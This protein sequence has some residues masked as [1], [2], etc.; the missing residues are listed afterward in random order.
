[1]G[2]T[3]LAM[4][5]LTLAATMVVAT[6]VSQEGALQTLRDDVRLGPPE[7]VSVPSA[8]AGT[9][10]EH[11]TSHEPNGFENADTDSL[12]L[13]GLY[14]AGAAVTSPIWVPTT[15]LGD[16]LT[17]A[18][19]F[20][21]YPYDD[22]SGYIQPLD[23]SIG[24]KP[25]AVRLDV[26]YVETFDCLDNLG[27]HLLV[28]SA[29]RL[30]VDASWNHLEERFQDNRY[31]SLEIGDV[32]LVYRFAQG[33][34]AEFR[35]GLGVNWLSDAH[36]TNLGFNFTYS[37]DFY[38]RKPWVLSAVIDWGTLGHTGLFRGRTTVGVVFHHVETYVGYEYS[39][40]GRTQW[41]GLI[42][43]LRFWF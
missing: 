10:M 3:L 15:F 39:D 29:S 42:G 33:N 32:N 17:S 5:M 41:N 37:A 4:S 11:H 9:P 18:G 40:I 8:P 25:F 34:W 35:A 38:P 36:D 6:A 7:S 43:G 12:C 21:P 14:F 30:G 1:M 27:G 28:D 2:R 26:E 31:D 20:P 24:T 16:D 23:S 19:Y 22:V 13:A